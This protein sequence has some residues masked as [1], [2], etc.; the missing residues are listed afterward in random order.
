V[1]RILVNPLFWA[2]LFV[3]FWLLAITT[4]IAKDPEH[5][6]AQGLGTQQTNQFS[7]R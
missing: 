2:I 5:A 1:P 6:K 4:S 7:Q 3:L